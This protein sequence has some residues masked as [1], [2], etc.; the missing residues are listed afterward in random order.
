[1]KRITLFAFMLLFVIS[2]NAQQLKGNVSDASNNTS[3]IGATIYVAGKAVTTTDNLGSF[4]IDCKGKTEIMVSYVGFASFRKTVTNCNEEL[5]IKLERIG[6][7]LD[8]VEITATSNPNKQLL[9]QPVSITKLNKAELNR[10]NGLFLDDAINGNVPGVTMNRRSVSGGQQ[11][12]IRGYGNGV[13]GTNGA[14]S[15]FDGQGYK[16]YLNGIPITDAEGITVLDDIDF[17]SIGNVEVVKGPAGTLYGLAIAGVVNLETMKPEKGK[18]SVGQDVMIGNFGLRRFTTH[19]AVG[20]E[21]SS[22]LVNYGNQSS[23]GFMPH[24]TSEKNFVNISG[25]FQPNS[26]QSID[27]YF[28]YTSSYDERAGELTIDQYNNKDYSG[29]PAY[30]KNNA[31]SEVIGFRAGL[32]HTYYFN[33]V[34]SNKTTVFGTGITNNASSAGGW[35]DKNPVNFGIRSTFDTK[36]S[37]ANGISLNG[38]TGV[39]SQRQQAQTIGYGMVADSSN[40]SGYNKIGAMRSNQYTISATTSLFTEWALILPH[41]LSLIAGIGWS[42]MKIELNDRF[43]VPGSTKPTKYTNTFNGL[44]SPHIGINKVLSK[45][46]SLYASY[47]KGYKAPVSSYFFIPTTGQVNTGLKPEIGSQFEI[48]TKGQSLNNKLEYQLALFYT[49][50]KD[51]MTAVAVPLS[52]GIATAY[53]YIANGGDQQNKGIEALLKYTAFQSA[54]GFLRTVRPWANVTYSNFTYKDFKFETLSSDRTQV[55]VNDYSGKD[56]AGVAP[57]VANIGVDFMAAAGLYANISYNYKDPMPITSDNVYNASSYNLLNAKIG[58]QR[59]LSTHFDID[60]YFGVN[61]ITGVQ[62]YNMVFINQLPDAYIPAPDKANYFG[63]INLKYNF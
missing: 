27:A 63:G 24:N 29:N 48:G 11:F 5:T 55:V 23:D 40:L 31:H 25:N 58:L 6:T 59:N 26:K 28:G 42:N 22:L 17:N 15:N 46:F 53:S 35:T 20:G 3:L 47:S 56:A 50:I 43:F 19:L 18:V 33:N 41:D 34:I 52:S 60:I 49:T 12:N 1:M 13:R 62:Y 10:G 39:E 21:K 30:I 38:I 54:G 16:V 14:S 36:F 7:T 57:I 8:K 61:N 9:Y 32:S 44:F 2:A 4:S 45:Q 37:L 51:K